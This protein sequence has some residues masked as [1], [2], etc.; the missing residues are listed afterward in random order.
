MRSTMVNAHSLALKLKLHPPSTPLCELI[1]PLGGM[2]LKLLC[3]LFL[4]SAKFTGIARF[5]LRTTSFYI[6]TVTND[7]LIGFLL[8]S[9]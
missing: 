7:E 8:G 5:L 3:C 9:W 2:P 1:I 4:L 6:E